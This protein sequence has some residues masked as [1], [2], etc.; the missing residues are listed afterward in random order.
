MEAMKR[1][2]GGEIRLE[3]AA[4]TDCGRQRKLNEDAVYHRTAGTAPIGLYIVCDGLGG[5]QA[6][7]VASRVAVETV[8]QELEAIFGMVDHPKP[9]QFKP[10]RLIEAAI[11]AANGALRQY[12]AA[13]KAHIF[14]IGTTLTLAMVHEQT[15]YVA[16]VGDSRA[17]VWRQGQLTQLTQ[18]HSLVAEMAEQGLIQEAE[19]HGHP[20][21]NILSRAVGVED[22][23][24]ADLLTWPLRPGDKL[25]L[26]SDGLW[27]AFPDMRVVA[28]W[29][30]LDMTPADYCNLLVSAANRQDG[31]D[32]IS[33][34]V[35]TT[36]AAA[37]EA[38]HLD[39][40]ELYETAPML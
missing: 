37:T 30:D 14:G 5:F 3:A 24:Q 31:S 4:L 16:H 39:T 23:V 34:V 25:L 40:Q 15:V 8:A 10:E 19:M 35:V 12:V 33:A 20:Q 32:N 1:F 18:D 7:E 2:E 17:Y 27:K 21:S 36:E 29:L 13:N 28:R 6:G 38:S 11:N 22:Q 9:A 26:C